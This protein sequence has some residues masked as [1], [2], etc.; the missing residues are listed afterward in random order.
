MIAPG[1]VSV[2]LLLISKSFWIPTVGTHNRSGERVQWIFD[3]TSQAVWK[4]LLHTVEEGSF[5]RI[6]GSVTQLLGQLRSEDARVRNEAAAAIWQRYC[7]TLLD[8]ACRNLNRRLRRRVEADDVVQHMFKSFFLRQQRGDYNLADRSDLLQLLVRMTL[9]KARSAASRE[10]R[11]RRDYRRDQSPSTSAADVGNEGDWFLDQ[12]E[13]GAPTPAEAVALAEAAEQRLLQLPDDLRQ[14]ALWKLEGYT[15]AE[16][17]ALP[18]M[19]CAERT[20]ERKLK[21][22]REFWGVPD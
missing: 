17:A 5:V 4:P 16:I 19:D 10:S 9:N 18:T 2:L 22:I 21:L 11:R 15:N 14:I 8:L 1:R 3:Q 12:A 20:V 7:G 6:P 13:Q